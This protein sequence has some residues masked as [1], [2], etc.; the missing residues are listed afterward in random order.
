MNNNFNNV[1][2]KS[3]E[4]PFTLRWRV[5]PPLLD[6]LRKTVITLNNQFHL[7]EYK[8][9]SEKPTWIRLIRFKEKKSNK[10]NEEKTKRKVS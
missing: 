9:T 1:G 4:Q 8:L 6:T 3:N 7:I 10:Q 5:P 2:K